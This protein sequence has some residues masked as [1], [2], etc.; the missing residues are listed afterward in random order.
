MDKEMDEEL[1]SVL[2]RYASIEAN[3]AI[4]VK[5]I[6]SENPWNLIFVVILAKARP[7]HLEIY[8]MIKVNS[9][10]VT[11]KEDRVLFRSYLLEQGVDDIDEFIKQVNR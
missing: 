1:R 6:D 8:N 5:P 10:Y 7:E 2:S 4:T 9:E 11:S 3:N